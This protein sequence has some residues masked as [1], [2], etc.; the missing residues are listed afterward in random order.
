MMACRSADAGKCELS[1]LAPADVQAPSAW[2]AASSVA[3]GARRGGRGEGYRGRGRG[4]P[5]EFGRGAGR[6]R[7]RGGR[8]AGNEFQQQGGGRGPPGN[9]GT[10]GPPG[11]SE[12]C[13][14][15]FCRP[16]FLPACQS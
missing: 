15:C 3:A 6:G 5:G 14:P 12:W 13:V 11:D 4:P 8:S 1:L 9:L 10:G 7:G 2:R 16:S